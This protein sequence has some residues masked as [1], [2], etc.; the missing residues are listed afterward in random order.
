MNALGLSA[1]PMILSYAARASYCHKNNE[2]IAKFTSQNLFL[3][4]KSLSNSLTRINIRMKVYKCQQRVIRKIPRKYAVDLSRQRQHSFR[5][6]GT[7]S[8]KSSAA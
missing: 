7:A 1:V 8:Y 2:N 3:R 5:S 4:C 6:K